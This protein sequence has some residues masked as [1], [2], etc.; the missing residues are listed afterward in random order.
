MTDFPDFNSELFEVGKVIETKFA[1]NFTEFKAVC[2]GRSTFI[3]ET[4]VPILLS[5][6]YQCLT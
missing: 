5:V 3:N 6:I 1:L 2:E 4:I